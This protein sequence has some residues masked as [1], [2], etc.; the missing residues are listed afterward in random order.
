VIQR[1]MVFDVESNG[2]HG[3]GFAVGW[4]HL[5][6]DDE[7]GQFEITE[8]EIAV[9]P[10][11]APT[12]PWVIEHV[13]PALPPPTHL[14]I[15]G[16]RERFTTRHYQMSLQYARLAADVV[17][18]VESNFL[19]YCHTENFPGWRAPYPLIDIASVRLGAGLDPLGD[20]LRL[21]VELPIHNPLADA[22]QSAR[23]LAQALSRS[24]RP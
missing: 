13:L 17:W 14:D 6:Y 24:P 2:L 9:A 22:R 12:D 11:P 20:E 18:P 4:V 1:Y 23:L 21:P 16:I 19:R 10:T 7:S 8:P 3:L 15:A 5:A